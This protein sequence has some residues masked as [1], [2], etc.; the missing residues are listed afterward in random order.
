MSVDPGT[1]RDAKE[2][3][4]AKAAD[5]LIVAA[6]RLLALGP[7]AGATQAQIDA[8]DAAA[9]AEIDAA[10][11]VAEAAPWPQVAAAYTDIADTGAGV[12]K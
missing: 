3:E 6:R 9:K 7:T 4:A 12:W 10:L 2:V 5:P 8:I 11:A 1:Y